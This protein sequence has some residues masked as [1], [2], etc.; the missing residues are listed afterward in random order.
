MKKILSAA[1]FMLLFNPA[2]A[3]KSLPEDMAYNVKKEA[4]KNS[5]MDELMQYSTDLMGPRLAGSKLMTRAEELTAKKLKELGLVNVRVEEASK[6]SKGGWDNQKTYAAMTAPYYCNFYALPKAWSGSTNGLVSGT[7]IV[8]DATSEQE[9]AQYKGK[10]AGKIIIM[11]STFEYVLD[12]EPLAVRYTDEQLAEIAKDARGNTTPRS[13]SMY[14]GMNSGG[15]NLAKSLNAMFEQERP[16]VVISGRGDFNIPG[17]GSVSYRMGDKEPVAELVLPA[18][19]HARMYRL[20]KSGVPVSMDVEVKNEFS[21]NNSINNVI[22]EIPG[23][24][25]KLKDEVVLIGGHLDSWHGGT[26]AEDN[27]SGVVV[28]MEAMRIIKAMGI[29]PR[30]TIR[31]ALWGGE[32]QGLIGSRGYLGK[33]LYDRDKKEKKAGFDKFALY[34]NMDNG[35]GK[36]RGIYLEEND[37]AVPFFKE[38]M[39]HFQAMGFNTLTLQKTS[40]TDHIMFQGVGLPGFQFIQDDLDYNRTYHTPMDTYERLSLPD[41]KYNAAVAAWVALCAAMDDQKIPA[42]PL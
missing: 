37:M 26:G 40:G 5:H 31:I 38:W 8:V 13:R 24:D 12:M 16:A 29:A 39:K 1:L 42:E 28:M 35:S 18:E 17:C 2:F 11:P 21:E 23:T 30:R 14:R 4:L 25:P 3:Q 22:G 41:L 36:F 32:E 9:L 15:F 20:V 7:V 19:A 10:L 27:A 33:Y 34:L 6:F